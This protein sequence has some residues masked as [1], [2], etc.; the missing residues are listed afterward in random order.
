MLDDGSFDMNEIEGHLWRLIM[1]KQILFAIILVVLLAVMT[2][3]KI[4]L[5]GA[6][7]T[8]DAQ[9][10]AATLDQEQILVRCEGGELQAYEVSN[11]VPNDVSGK[12]LTL[13]LEPEQASCVESAFASG[14]GEVVFGQMEST[15]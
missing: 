5:I 12:R 6:M 8:P 2:L 15:P 1:E 14:A 7:E 3:T 13:M 4:G 9:T 11:P 10:A